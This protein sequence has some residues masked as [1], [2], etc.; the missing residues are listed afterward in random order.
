MKVTSIH[1]LD[2]RV[3]WEERTPIWRVRATCPGVEDDAQEYEI[4]DATFADVRRIAKRFE[5]QGYDVELLAVA[6]YAHDE[7]LIHI[8]KWNRSLASIRPF[9]KSM[10]RRRATPRA[11]LGGARPEL[12]RLAAPLLM[13][14]LFS[15][16][17]W[18]LRALVT[19]H[20]SRSSEN[21]DGTASAG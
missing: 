14:V 11:R 5:A 15:A 12:W 6:P 17:R 7:G 3:P 8:T 10:A 13:E 18:F 2:R 1:P 21:D 20:L 19:T 9:T 16:D 4:A